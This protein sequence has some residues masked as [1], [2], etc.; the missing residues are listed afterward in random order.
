MDS[1]KKWIFDVVLLLVITSFTLITLLHDE[2]PAQLL[3]LL[4]QANGWYWIAAAVLIIPFVA[5]ESLILYILLKHVGANPIP[6]HCLIYSFT[7]FFFSCITPAAGGGQPAQIYYMRKD[8]LNPGITTP[9]LIIV[10]ICYKLVLVIAGIALFILRPRSLYIMDDAAIVWAVIGWCVN[11]V[12]ITFFCLLIVCP[13]QVE[14]VCLKLLSLLSKTRI[15]KDRLEKWRVRLENAIA[16]YRD[17]TRTLRNSLK[18]VFVVLIISIFQRGILF[19]VTWFV[20]RSFHVMNSASLIEVILLQSMISLG[21]DMIPL[22][23]GSGANEAMFML[24]FNEL[25]GEALVLPVL[26]ASRGISYYGQL[27]ICGFV[28]FAFSRIIGRRYRHASADD[29]NRNQQ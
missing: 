27:L 2:N 4:D 16:N 22:P 25:C 13:R 29:P 20:L 1:K 24:L 5:C 11:V 6:G 7:G 23:G 3:R 12:V 18:Q 21:T 14:K 26:I 8:G 15:K 19:S 9:I 17:V 28:F 10:T